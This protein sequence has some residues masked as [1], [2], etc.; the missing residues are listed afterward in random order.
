MPGASPRLLATPRWVRLP[1]LVGRR[2]DQETARPLDKSK[3]VTMKKL[4]LVSVAL[5]L[6]ASSGAKAHSVEVNP[7]PYLPRAFRR[8]SPCPVSIGPRDRSEDH[9][10][11]PRGLFRPCVHRR[12]SMCLS[13]RFS[14]GRVV[15]GGRHTLAQED[16]AEVLSVGRDRWRNSRLEKPPLTLANAAGSL[17]RNFW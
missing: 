10:R 13:A 12:T 17:R 14:Q 8:R 1:C 7:L 15:V 6:A 4:L 2:G 11:E 5:L 3:T 9:S 16:G